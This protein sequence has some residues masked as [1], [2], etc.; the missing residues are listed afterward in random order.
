MDIKLPP[1]L[2][3]RLHGSIQRFVSE[4]YGADMG[5]LGAATFL[6]FCLKEIGPAVYNQAIADAHAYLQEHIADL[7]NVCFA[8]ETSFWKSEAGRAVVR[9][10][11]LRRAARR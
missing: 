10:P 3:K 8:E 9:K 11:E 7:E 5:E 6:A 1:E 4:Q 2:A